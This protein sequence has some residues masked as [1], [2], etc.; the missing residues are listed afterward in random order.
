VHRRK[1]SDEAFRFFLRLISRKLRDLPAQDINEIG[2]NNFDRGLS[3]D[4][5]NA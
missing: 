5:G 2:P 1:T 3:I 4:H